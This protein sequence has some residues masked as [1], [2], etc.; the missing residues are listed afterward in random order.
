MA[1]KLSMFRYPKFVTVLLG[2][3]LMLNA[4]S[5][6]RSG[7]GWIANVQPQYVCPGDHVTVSWDAGTRSCIGGGCP[8]PLRVDII[9]A[10]AE[11]LGLLARQPSVGTHDA[12][13]I[14]ADTS[15]TF[16]ASGGDGHFATEHASVNVVLPPPAVRTVPLEFPSTCSGSAV[17][18]T[19]IDLSAPTTFRS[20]AVRLLNICNTS[21]DTVNLTLTFTAS[22]PQTWTLTPGTCTSPNPLDPALG[23]TVLSARVSPLS[24]AVVPPGGCSVGSSSLPPPVSVVASLECDLTSAT[25]PLVYVTPTEIPTKSDIIVIPSLTSTSEPGK[26]ILIL[27]RNANCRQ[28]PGSAY[29]AIDAYP[30][31]QSLMADGRNEDAPWW[32]QVQMPNS[33]NHCWV[34]SV[35]GMPQG[36]YIQ[37]PVNKSPQ[38]PGEPAQPAP[39]VDCKQFSDQ[40]ACISAG[41]AW[42]PN[43][44]AC[45]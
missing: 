32:W 14:N 37:L 45:K 2:A 42:N 12:G 7:L 26:Q 18:W 19:P 13:P 21:P 33:K 43:L 6:D 39:P 23:Q 41:C 44:Q 15:F 10:P 30:A 16:N 31:G 40:N 17:G 25:A 24:V 11:P 34:S 29:D 22:A 8:P 4:C 1:M 38:L 5:A 27:N 3:A 20:S 28:G 36:D 35:A 9:S